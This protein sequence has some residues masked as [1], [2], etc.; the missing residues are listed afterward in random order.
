M[1]HLYKQGK[2]KMN[3][4][5]LGEGSIWNSWIHHE[6]GFLEGTKKYALVD[7]THE[8]CPVCLESIPDEIY[9]AWKFHNLDGLQAWS[10]RPEGHSV[11]EL[12]KEK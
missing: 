6:C 12:M 1:G 3:S 8:H 7:I 10:K 5:S 4:M 9:G 11:T 2:W